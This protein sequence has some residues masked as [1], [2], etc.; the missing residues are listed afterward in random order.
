MSNHADASDLIW[1][2][3]SIISCLGGWPGF[4][5]RNPDVSRAFGPFRGSNLQK[6]VDPPFRGQL[7]GHTPKEAKPAYGGS[8]PKRGST[9]V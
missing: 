4:R 8:A 6:G 5:G 7:G 2:T 3:A 9:P 1:A